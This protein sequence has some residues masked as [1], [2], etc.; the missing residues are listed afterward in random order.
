MSCP[1]FD[2]VTPHS[3]VLAG[4]NLKPTVQRE[5]LTGDQAVER[6]AANDMFS[7]H[8]SEVSRFVQKAKLAESLILSSVGIQVILY[9]TE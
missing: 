9:R 3:I 5:T 6:I 2:L 8:A 1:H 4:A 7:Q